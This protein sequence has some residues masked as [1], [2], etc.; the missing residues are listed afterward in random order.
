MTPRVLRAHIRP[1]PEYLPR[2]KA[3][4]QAI[5]VGVGFDGAWYRSQEEHW[6]GWLKEYDSPGAYDRSDKAKRDAETIYNRIQCAPM[7]FWLGEALQLPPAQ[8]DAAFT[9]VVR[10]EAKGGPQCAALRSVTSWRDIAKTFEATDYARFDRL[11][12]R[13]AGMF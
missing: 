9:A 3:L 13:L 4:E 2:T 7:L 5:Q 8:L 6:L 1:L 12:I 11:R 10:I